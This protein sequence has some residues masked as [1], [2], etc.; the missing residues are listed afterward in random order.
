MRRVLFVLV[1]GAAVV[2]ALAAC[3]PKVHPQSTFDEDDPRA[4][5]GLAEAPDAGVAGSDAAGPVAIAPGTPGARTGTLT[6]AQ[7]NAVLDAGP[8][9]LLRGLEVAAL[10]PDDK[11]AGWKLVRFVAPA[12]GPHLFDTVDLQVGDVLRKLNGRTL[13]TPPDLS[14]LWLELYTAAA[15]DATLERDGQTVTLH[16]DVTD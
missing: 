6:R 14:A 12:G 5:H 2:T 15:I 1:T 3:G 4:G 11:F 13:E 9:E 10:R 8:A 16:F 7:V